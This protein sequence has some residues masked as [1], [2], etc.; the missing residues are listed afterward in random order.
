M[1]EVKEQMLRARELIQQKQYDEARLLLMTIDHD[2]AREWLAQLDRI[3]QKQPTPQPV[4]SQPVAPQPVNVTV[5]EKRK[6]PGCLGISLGVGCGAPLFFCIG[7]IV[8][9][10]VIAAV[11]QSQKEDATEKIVDANAGHG[12]LENPIPVGQWAAFT[13][14]QVTAQRIVRPATEMVEGF[15]QFNSNPATGAEYVLLWFDLRCTEDRCVPRVDLKIR[16]VDSAGKQ[17]GEPTIV[18]LD[19][20]FDDTD[21][22]SGAA[23]GGWQ[24]FEYPSNEPIQAIWI[25]WGDETLYL[26]PP[27]A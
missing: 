25:E 7:L 19:D 9:V 27:T 22:V 13:G 24:A 12:T 23:I 2:K 10:A 26:L 16:L 21:A 3:Q 17:W 15:N 6:V 5:K 8:I 20:D 14:G 4:V 11:I 1:S 18:M